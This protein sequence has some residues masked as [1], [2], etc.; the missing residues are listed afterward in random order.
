[1]LRWRLCNGRTTDVSFSWKYAPWAKFHHIGVGVS[2]KKH[3]SNYPEM[4]GWQIKSGPSAGYLECR[5][6]SKPHIFKRNPIVSFAIP[7]HSQECSLPLFLV[8]ECRQLSVWPIY[9]T[10]TAFTAG[11]L[12]LMGLDSIGFQWNCKA[13]GL[14][15]ICRCII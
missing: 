12:C 4:E 7:Q 3:A 11:T 2:S 10:S 1:M 13:K 15:C 9:F 8:V 14:K 5:A 6:K